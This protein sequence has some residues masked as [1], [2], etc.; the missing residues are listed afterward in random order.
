MLWLWNLTKK[1]MQNPIRC[2]LISLKILVQDFPLWLNEI[3]GVSA[4]AGTLVLSPAPHSGLRIWCYHS[5]G[6]G[7]ISSL[8]LVLGLG[9][10]YP[11]GSQ[12]KK[13]KK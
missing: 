10:P 13:K 12:K 3:D 7:H 6:I 2:H 4:V 11:W 9:T 5:Y 1:E 8:D